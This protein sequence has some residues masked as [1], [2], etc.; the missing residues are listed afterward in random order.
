MGEDTLLRPGTEV[1]EYIIT[2][3]IGR[4]G[5]GVVYRATHPELGNAVAIKVIN[6]HHAWEPDSVRRFKREARL[7][8]QLNHPN[9]VNVFGFGSLP[10]GR[11]YYV[12]DFLDGDSLYRILKK[13]GALSPPETARIILAIADGLAAAHDKHIIHRDIKPS[14]IMLMRGGFPKLLDFGIAK[15]NAPTSADESSTDTGKLPG[16]PRYMAPE[17]ARGERAIDHRADIYQLGLVAYECLTGEPAFGSGGM[18]VGEILLHQQVTPPVF[19]TLVN[20]ALPPEIDAP[21][22]KALEKEAT[23]RQQHVLAFA[24][25]LCLA[26]GIDVT[27]PIASISSYEQPGPSTAA[28]KRDRP[29]G[30]QLL[31]GRPQRP[32]WLLPAVLAAFVLAAGGAAF[33]IFGGSATETTHADPSA[34]NQLPVT[35]SNT[36]AK[37]AGAAALKIPH[38][39]RRAAHPMLEAW[40]VPRRSG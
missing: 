29:A 10:D 21:I 27:G 30:T 31:D 2:E 40:R 34:Q 6:M 36:F 12:M 24:R 22:C 28:T 39:P 20:P 3:S 19:P 4:G 32:A 23:Q 33:A 5:M 8:S 18:P 9:I 37:N 38:P 13:R 25:E 16:T 15:L 35:Q 11:H 14:N 26:A 7:I 1:G 17:Q